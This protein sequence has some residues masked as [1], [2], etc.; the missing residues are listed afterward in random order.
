[1]DLINSVVKVVLDGASLP[2][3]LLLFFCA[4]LLYLLIDERKARKEES[5][6]NA[7]ALDRNTASANELARAVSGIASVVSSSVS[8]HKEASAHVVSAMDRIAQAVHSLEVRVAS[9]SKGT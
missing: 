8:D 6:I 4:I 2:V 3:H 1:M 9:Y 7:A 5:L